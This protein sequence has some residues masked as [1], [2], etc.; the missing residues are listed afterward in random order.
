[1]IKKTLLAFLKIPAIT[2][3]AAQNESLCD[4]QHGCEQKNIENCKARICEEA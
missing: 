1:M 2:S 4:F 3:E